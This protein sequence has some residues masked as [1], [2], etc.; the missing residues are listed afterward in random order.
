[1]VGANWRNWNSPLA[2]LDAVSCV[3]VAVLVSVIF[4][5][6]TIAP[7]ASFTKPV[8]LPVGEASSQPAQS[9]S[10]AAGRSPL[11]MGVLIGFEPRYVS[12]VRQH[13]LLP[14]RDRLS[15]VVG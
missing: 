1:M 8:M 6:G 15:P 10:S 13:T 9:S 11:D 2:S 4:A 14:V 7:E 12:Y 5:P 3:L